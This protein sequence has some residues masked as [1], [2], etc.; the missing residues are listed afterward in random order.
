MP[1]LV[2]TLA[3]I[4]VAI[5]GP[6]LI[7]YKS[8]QQSINLLKGRLSRLGGDT[9]LGPAVYQRHRRRTSDGLVVVG[10]VL[11]AAAINLN[12]TGHP[13]FLAPGLIGV[14][15]VGAGVWGMG[16]SFIAAS[17]EIDEMTAASKVDR[18]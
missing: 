3:L 18:E 11:G 2:N 12:V 4:A 13:A 5:V 17:K 7:T 6:L 14:A 8:D 1:P 16:R 9:R 15:L 10:S